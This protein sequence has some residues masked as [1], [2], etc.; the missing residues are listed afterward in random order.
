MCLLQISYIE[1]LLEV[2]PLP[3]GMWNEVKKRGKWQRNS[4][5]TLAIGARDKTVYSWKSVTLPLAHLIV[6]SMQLDTL[7][8]RALLLVGVFDSFAQFRF[9]SRPNGPHIT[10]LCWKIADK[11][12]TWIMAMNTD[13][14]WWNYAR[15]KY[16]RYKQ[17]KFLVLY[18]GIT[19]SNFSNLLNNINGLKS[20]IS[21]ILHLKNELGNVVNIK[22]LI[23]CV[24]DNQYSVIKHK[25]LFLYF[26]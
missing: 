1:G 23:K 7:Y 19:N 9:S 6:G 8:Y 2:Q 14:L 21:S 3:G 5:I 25:V 4:H 12:S 26:E 15:C 16:K 20:L 11:M 10:I 22:S 18:L 17:I 13:D 24:F